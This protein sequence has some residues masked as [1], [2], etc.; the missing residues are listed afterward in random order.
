[1]LIKACLPSDATDFKLLNGNE[2]VSGIPNL[3]P[4]V[5]TTICSA[6]PIL[7]TTI[8]STIDALILNLTLWVLIRWHNITVELIGL[9]TQI[10]F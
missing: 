6:E 7:L 3:P 2:E 10:I 5:T 8:G 9:D 4:V 1:M